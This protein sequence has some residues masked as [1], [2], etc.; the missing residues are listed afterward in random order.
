MIKIAFPR[1]HFFGCWD[2][3]TSFLSAIRYLNKMNVKYDYFTV[4][5]SLIDENRN[6]I[7]KVFLENKEEYLLMIDCDMTFKEDSIYKLYETMKDN[8]LDICCGLFF[9]GEPGLKAAI[10][11]DG[12]FYENYP[13]NDLF[14]IDACGMAFTMFS[15][16]VVEMFENEESFQR[17]GTLSEDLSFCHRAKEKGFKIWCDSKIKIGHLRLKA[18][19]EDNLDK[20]RYEET[21]WN[22]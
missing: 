22:K 18:I 13:S 20:W 14:E 4:E 8:K 5:S 3:F 19:T 6:G 11:K 1:G 16:R 9:T 12:I 17:I 21:I 15:K 7:F 2:F 10:K